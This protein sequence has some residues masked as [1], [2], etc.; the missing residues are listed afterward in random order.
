M[1]TALAAEGGEEDGYAVVRP[2][3]VGRGVD[4]GRGVNLGRGEGGVLRG[5]VAGQ[6]VIHRC[7][8]AP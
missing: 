8:P 3:G 4:L 7:V 5:V 1:I 6:L 2:D